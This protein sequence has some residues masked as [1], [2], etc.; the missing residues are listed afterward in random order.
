[1]TDLKTEA[2]RTHYLE[3]VKINIL[4]FCKGARKQR[5]GKTQPEPEFVFWRFQADRSLE[6]GERGRLYLLSGGKVVA[7]VWMIEKIKSHH[8][9]IVVVV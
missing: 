6:I 3:L 2:F 9:T 1:M 7:F 5:E 4:N 8:N